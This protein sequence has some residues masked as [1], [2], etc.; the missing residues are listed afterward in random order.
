MR[1]I[2][3]V[4][5]TSLLC[6]AFLTQ[7][8]AQSKTAALQDSIILTPQKQLKVIL[9]GKDLNNLIKYK[10]TDSILQL[11]L[12]DFEKALQQGLSETTKVS[13]YLV[14]PSGKRRFKA[15]NEDY[16]E[17]IFS[18]ADESK[19]LNLELPTQAYYIYDLETNTQI[20]VFATSTDALKTLKEYKL[21]EAIAS[22]TFSK[23]L[24]RKNSSLVLFNENN[25]W[26]NLVREKNP[27]DLI[28]FSP[29]F[30]MSAIGSQLS[31]E[32]GL[33]MSFL[34]M[35]KYGSPKWTFGLSYNLN[36]ISEFST[37]D[38]KGVTSLRSVNAFCMKHGQGEG[39]ALWKW[40][41]FQ[42]G[43]LHLSPGLLNNSF[44]LG[45]I[46]QYRGVHIG[47]HSYFI[48]KPISPSQSVLY[49]ASILF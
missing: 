33:R 46:T 35:N 41:G 47:F 15:E 32:V 43:Y 36:L 5:T 29:L 37:N 49:G 28:E 14:H 12:I 16:Q 7:A 22:Q 27:G 19:K 38:F 31:P 23:E 13:H 44:K 30:G 10:R 26:Q 3:L 2:P 4:L 40:L 6:L 8:S 34:K 42:V 24:L 17:A 45:I 11:F 1:T 18:L 25:R 20:Q 9:I 48:Q 39:E 21:A